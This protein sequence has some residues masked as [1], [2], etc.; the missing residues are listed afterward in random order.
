MYAEIILPLPLY[1]T[2]TYEIPAGADEEVSV[3]SRVLVQ[4]GRKNSI[5]E[6]WRE[7]TT[8]LRHTR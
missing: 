3:G 6:S 7:S 2:F 8:R 4:F 1:G 5:P